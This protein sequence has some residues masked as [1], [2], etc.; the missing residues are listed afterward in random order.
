MLYIRQH[1]HKD[2]TKQHLASG[3]FKTGTSW[4]QLHREYLPTTSKCNDQPSISAHDQ[5]RYIV[6][7]RAKAN[8]G[9]QWSGQ[10]DPRL[11][12]V[13]VKEPTPQ[14]GSLWMTM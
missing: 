14:C 12:T 3:S 7:K 13:W 4:Q 1:S 2:N 11:D 9:R 8:A 6:T 10:G 5:E